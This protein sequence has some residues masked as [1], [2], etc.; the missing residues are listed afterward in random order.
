MQKLLRIV[1]L[2]VLSLGVFTSASVRA[3][4][5]DDTPLGKAMSE[6]NKNMKVV[7][8]ALKAGDL[9]AVVA[10]CREA[11]KA[12]IKSFEFLPASFDKIPAAE[13]DKATADYHLQLSQLHTKLIELEIACMKGDKEAAGKIG[14]SIGELKKK[15]HDDYKKD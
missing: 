8:K 14:A 7:G 4:E 10:P 15:G 11:Q 6:M 5:K 13:K 1:P 9:A 12:T 3:E 2:L